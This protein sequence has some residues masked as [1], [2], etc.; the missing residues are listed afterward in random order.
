MLN[1]L[2]EELFTLPGISG[3]EQEVKDYLKNYFKN[4]SNYQIIQDNLG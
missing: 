4:L 1:K 2:Y 3:F